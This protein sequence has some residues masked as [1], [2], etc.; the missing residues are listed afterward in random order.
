MEL[1]NSWY[2]SDIGTSKLRNLVTFAG[3]DIHEAIHVAN[4]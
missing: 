3:V 2:G 1:R 4:T